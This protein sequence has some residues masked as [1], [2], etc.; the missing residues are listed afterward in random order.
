M[1]DKRAETEIPLVVDVDGT[2]VSGDLLF[3]GMARLLADSPLSLAVLL[4]RTPR[5]ITA[6]GR[7]ALKR[8]V[9]EAVQLPPETVVLNPAVLQEIESAK[10]AGRSVY[11]ASGADALAVRGLGQSVGAAGC[12][13]SDGKTNLVGHAKAVVLISRFGQAQ[14][15]YIGNEWRDLAVWRASRRAIGVGLPARLRQKV[16]ALDE[17]AKFL[18][19]FGNRP[20]DYFRALRPH[21]WVKNLLVFTPLIASHEIRLESYSTV[22]ILALAISAC[23]SGTYLLNDL[24]DL[25]DDRRH[26]SK[27][28]RPLAAGKLPLQNAAALAVGLIATGGAIAFSLS[29][30]AG[31]CIALYIVVTFIYSLW[32]KRMLFI[33]VVT[34]SVLYVIR[35]FSGATVNSIALSPWF[36]AFTTSIFLTL[37]IVKRQVELSATSASDTRIV[38]A[39]RRGYVAG[40]LTALTALSCASGI[41]SIVVLALYLQEPTVAERYEQ[42]EFLALICLL[43][44]YWLGR[45]IILANRGEVDDD[46]VVFGL[47]DRTSWV[48]AAA[49]IAI[50]LTAL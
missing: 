39:G 9:A 17:D 36:L 46:P 42:P 3:E 2:L 6:T 34:L 35:V 28:Y 24:L 45:L 41:G 37:A 11:L 44:L 29:V 15:D 16:R 38:G 31:F 5:A 30:E 26:R 50:F 19:G 40:D 10:A 21:Q 8:R 48:I 43:L 7:A 20:V 49:I 14:F 23:A 27:R 25:Q 13:C 4:F 18:P 32:I 22:T 12:L 33:D 1:T 47:R